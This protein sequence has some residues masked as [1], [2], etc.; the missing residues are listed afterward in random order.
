MIRAYRFEYKI[1]KHSLW[2]TDPVHI[3]ALHE[4]VHRM[5]RSSRELE[6]EFPPHT[7]PTPLGAEWAEDYGNPFRMTQRFFRP[8]PPLMRPMR[9]SIAGGAR[10]KRGSIGGCVLSPSRGV[11]GDSAGDP[12]WS[13]W[14][15]YSETSVSIFQAMP[16]RTPTSGQR[17]GRY[18]SLHNAALPPVERLALKRVAR[19]YSYERPGR[20]IPQR[21]LGSGLVMR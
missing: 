6:K 1:G 11:T 16:Q 2:E 3:G 19:R 14:R 18:G 5:T 21:D 15:R 13:L 9:G 17:T 8:K 20:M 4:W 10:T 12:S 7:G